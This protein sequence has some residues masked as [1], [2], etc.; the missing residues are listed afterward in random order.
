[1]HYSFWRRI[2]EMFPQS[3]QNRFWMFRDENELTALREKTNADFIEK[4]GANMSVSCFFN[5]L[6]YF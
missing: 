1:M 3:S 6:E 5:V 2:V 4:H